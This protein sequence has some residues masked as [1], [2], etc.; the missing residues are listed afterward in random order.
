MILLK[1]TFWAGFKY[2]SIKVYR[3][4]ILR[5]IKRGFSFSNIS[6]LTLTYLRTKNMN[7]FLIAFNLL[8]TNL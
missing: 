1:N 2:F 7:A 5:I 8:I 6:E 4:F 3:L